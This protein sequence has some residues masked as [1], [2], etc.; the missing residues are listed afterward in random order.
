MQNFSIPSENTSTLRNTFCHAGQ[1]GNN[2]GY[3]T[4]TNA[5][6]KNT[7]FKYMGMAGIPAKTAYIKVGH[8]SAAPASIGWIEYGVFRGSFTPGPS[9]S[10]TLRNLGT[11]D[12]QNI[13]LNPGTAYSTSKTIIVPLDPPVR[14][15]DHLWIGWGVSAGTM[16]VFYADSKVDILQ[17]G[18]LQTTGSRPSLLGTAGSFTTSP[19]V[20]NS[21]YF[22][23]LFTMDIG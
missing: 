2:T 5:A 18:T 23:P 16:P 6:D 4:N 8:Q 14:P 10:A 19:P 12:A 1:C 20:Y 21:S 22:P 11:V 3:T 13:I 17:A 9:G 15:G 7:Y